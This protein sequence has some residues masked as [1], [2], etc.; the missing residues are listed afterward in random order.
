MFKCPRRNSWA[1]SDKNILYLCEIASCK[2]S[3]FKKG[4][5]KILS[6]YSPPLPALSC[7]SILRIR[8]YPGVCFLGLL[9]NHGYFEGSWDAVSD[10]ICILPVRVS[11]CQLV[12][13]CPTCPVCFSWAGRPTNKKKKNYFG[14]VGSSFFFFFLKL[15]LCSLTAFLRARVAVSPLSLYRGGPGKLSGSCKLIRSDSS[16]LQFQMWSWYLILLRADELPSEE[17]EF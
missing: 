6:W 1:R 9:E 8:N 13:V 4:I 2:Q 16:A 11:Q 7:H 12:V 3:C 10:A 15:N 14:E 17:R 5:G